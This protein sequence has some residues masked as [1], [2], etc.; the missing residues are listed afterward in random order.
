MP[1]QQVDRMA[2]G[3]ARLFVT[4][5]GTT[6]RLPVT[7]ANDLEIDLKIEL[8]EA[9][10]EGGFA[11]AVAD[12]HRSVDITGKHYSL[13]LNN[14][15]YDFNAAAPT[16]A[17]VGTAIDEAG[18]IAV[19]HT[20]ALTQA[21]TFIPGTATV[22]VYITVGGVQ[23]PVRFKVVAPGAEVV[24]ISCSITAG[25]ITFAA[26]EVVGAG[27]VVSYD[28]TF[29]API[30][31]TILLTNT[32]QNS[33]SPYSMTVFKRDRS[34]IDGSV[35][36]LRA[37]IFAVRPGGAKMP[38][39]E[40]DWASYDRTWKAFADPLGNVMRLSFYNV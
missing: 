31:S 1:I 40:G 30:G 39:K 17:T 25:V 20:Y 23:Y 28:Y 16:T 26:A 2:F 11:I 22:T 14:I 7:N 29:G 3:A 38:F 9:Y 36:I 4:P 8:K 13:D 37:D 6:Q 32:Y 12:G 15:A 21:A 10:A 34:P 33:S 27:I 5:Y 18:A 19:G 24:N 35:G